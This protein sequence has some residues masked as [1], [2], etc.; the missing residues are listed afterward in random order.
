MNET[1]CNPLSSLSFYC[2]IPSSH[3]RIHI[4][5]LH[6]IIAVVVVDCKMGI[7]GLAASIR[8]ASES[9]T[10]DLGGQNVT[11][12]TTT[13]K[14]AFHEPFALDHMIRITFVTGAGKQNRQKYDDHA[15]RA[16]TSV[17]HDFGYQEDRGASCVMECAGCY[18]LQHDTGKNLKT[19]VVFPR[20]TVP[21]KP[22]SL[23]IEPLLPE[24]SPEYKLAVSSMNVF[25]NMVKSKCPSW[26]QKKA[27]LECLQGVQE[28]LQA[29]DN[30]L[31]TATTITTALNA[32]EQAFY[33][34]VITLDDKVAYVRQELLHQVEIGNITKFE[35]KLLLD[36][37]TEKV[38]S[39]T[40]EQK[41]TTKA[42]QRKELLEAL[43]P[44]VPH[45]LKLEAEIYSL[46][47][48][49]V[50]LLALE[51]EARRRLLSIKETQTLARKVE[52]DEE[53]AY[54]EEASRGWF[55]EDDVFESRLEA[56][57]AKFETKQKKKALKM[58][59]IS[60]DTTVKINTK[61]L[62]PQE[63]KAWAKKEAAKRKKKEKGGC[64]FSSMI[65]DSSSD[66]EDSDEDDNDNGD[67]IEEDTDDDS[68]IGES[69][70]SK[71]GK[72]K[73]KKKKAS[74][75]LDEGMAKAESASSIAVSS[76]ISM[77][78]SFTVQLL[79]TVV[80]WLISLVFGKPKKAKRN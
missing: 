62:T 11:T 30:Q 38:A 29:L 71:S 34:A 52:I 47:K 33:D 46:R 23:E 10:F 27:C 12:I 75:Q 42:L 70:I 53:I 36:Q 72:R 7:S 4:T 79:L 28:R 74:R 37:N 45:G 41:S 51:K 78:V 64:A 73:R 24:D 19:V 69:A 66:E 26:S 3:I 59:S 54:L 8:D 39:L 48:E 15:A 25:K 50:P 6:C 40:N 77:V 80:A 67:G 68:P 60:A 1:P 57:R 17:L 76:T 35:Q 9:E 13:M 56:S 16:V 21:S 22:M 5:V 14:D 55:E 63:Q 61:W 65:M 58:I 44:I 31:M 49:R 18:K 43:D 2:T 20:I 32:S